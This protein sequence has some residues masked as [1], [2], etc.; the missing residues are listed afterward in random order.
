MH[1]EAQTRKNRALGAWVLGGCAILVLA[2]LVDVISQH[3]Q[4]QK[5]SI[6]IYCAAVLKPLIK[7]LALELEEKFK[8]DIKIQYGGS[9]ALLQQIRLADTGDL[10][11]S[12]DM[13]YIKKAKEYGIITTH[14]KVAK[15]KLVLATARENPR[16][17]DKLSDLQKWDYV[18]CDD[19]AAAGHTLRKALEKSHAYKKIK[20]QAKSIRQSVTLLASDVKMGAADAAFVWDVTAKQFGLRVVD[21][22]QLK[23][24][25]AIAAGAILKT[26]HH[27]EMCERFL[28]R[29]KNQ[30]TAKKLR[31]LGFSP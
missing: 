11:F 13:F 31:N 17:I 4:K 30:S 29:L 16:S 5:Q 19:R 22:V 1:N 18:I 28:K 14:Q 7:P 15:I 25:H 9:G 10:F 26:T 21:I 24:A 6:R 23:N 27:R 20:K 12:A 3:Y 2:L 8:M